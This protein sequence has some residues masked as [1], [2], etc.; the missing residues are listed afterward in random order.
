VQSFDDQLLQGIGRIHSASEALQAVIMAQEAGLKNINIDLI[1]GLPG[2]TVRQLQESFNQAAALGIPHISAY[3]L[4]VEEGT[5]F[6]ALEAQGLLALPDEESDEAMYDLATRF[7]P[8]HGFRRYEISNF[9]LP[10]MECRHNLK[11]WHYQPYLGV[12]VAAHSFLAGER[13]ANTTDVREYIQ[14]VG[15]G[16]LPVTFREALDLPT[17][18]A[19][20]VFL[21]LRTA[22]GMAIRD[23]NAYF[24]QDFFQQYANIVA[25]L[26]K[27][28]LL[29]VH[30]DSICLTE[31]GMKYGNVVFRAFLPNN[32]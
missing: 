3:G 32:T 30:H 16:R 20:F 11:Y 9:A 31:S 15:Q 18:M 22:N 13:S 23:F 7:L 19:E 6:A 17:A 27:R 4:K 8:K 25:N 2:Q 28:N 10:G 1:Y 24:H 21:A 26:K 5:P 12:G 14:Q 29:A